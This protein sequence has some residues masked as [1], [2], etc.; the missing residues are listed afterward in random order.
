MVQMLEKGQTNVS[1]RTLDKLARALGVSTGSLLGKKPVA[2]QDG[3]ALIEEVL[4]RNLLAAR[5]RLAL[6]QDQ[7]A[8]RA[9]LH[10]PVIAYI[11]NQSRNPSMVTLAKLADAAG[12][13]LEALLSS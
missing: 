2:R 8:E 9:G 7:L 1:L 11:E 5:R 6:T 4:A 13:S 12:V 10:R 3:E